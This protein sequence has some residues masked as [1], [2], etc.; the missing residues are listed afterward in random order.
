MAGL[1]IRVDGPEALQPSRMDAK[2]YPGIP[3]SILPQGEIQG[4]VQ[5]PS[6]TAMLVW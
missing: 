6:A 5:T 4:N 1:H 2:S 3:A